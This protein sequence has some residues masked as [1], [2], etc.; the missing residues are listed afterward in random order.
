MAAPASPNRATTSAASLSPTQ[1][2]I[3]SSSSSW[4]RRRPAWSSNQSSSIMSG[5]PTRRTVRSAVDWDE[6]E[7]PSQTPSRER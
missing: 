3:A 4:C 1:A 7:R 2:P 6:A 5:R